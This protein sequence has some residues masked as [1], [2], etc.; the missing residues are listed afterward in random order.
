MDPQHLETVLDLT[1]VTRVMVGMVMIYMTSMIIM[2]SM[3][4][5]IIMRGAPV[6][7]PVTMTPAPSP[8]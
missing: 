8:S 6:T 1:L 5:K 3:I 2:T 4:S 7:S